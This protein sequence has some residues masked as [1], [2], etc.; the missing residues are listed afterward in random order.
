LAEIVAHAGFDWLLIDAEH[1]PA[2]IETV[3]AM[4]RATSGTQATPTVRI[5]T[6]LGWRAKRVLDVGALGVMVPGVNSAEEA[7][8][9]A[10]AVRYPPEGTRGVGPTFAALRWGLSGE[11]YMR[12]ADREVMAILQIETVEAV[13]RID[14][15][16]AVPGVDLPLIGPYDLSA[17][18]GLLG[19]VDHPRVQEAIGRVLAATRKAGL[20]AGIFG[21]S[22]DEVNRFIEQGFLAILVGVDTAFLTAGAKA[23]LSRIAR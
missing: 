11:D 18:M 3:H 6:N 16:L 20:P 17:S 22:A 9:A 12:N 21:M 5:A 1:G 4:I 19:Q 15:I 23:T 8:A 10:R 2:G 13:D 7:L 14:E